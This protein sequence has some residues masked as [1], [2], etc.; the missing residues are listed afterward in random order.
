MEVGEGQVKGCSYRAGLGPVTAFTKRL[1]PL[2]YANRHEFIL[3]LPPL[4]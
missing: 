3:R 4:G 1:S 2:S